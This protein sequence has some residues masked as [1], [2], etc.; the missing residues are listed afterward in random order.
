MHCVWNS[1]LF[2]NDVVASEKIER[3]AV[4]RIFQDVYQIL[5]GA[6]LPP[7][8]N[9]FIKSWTWK[10]PAKHGCSMPN[11]SMLVTE[12]SW[13]VLCSETMIPIHSKIEE[14]NNVL[15]QVSPAAPLPGAERVRKSGYQCS[16]TSL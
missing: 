10:A 4:G 16:R 7:S 3:G 12:N 11:R 14:M 5:G 1:R 6:V 2:R 13:W 9:P 15:F 8:R